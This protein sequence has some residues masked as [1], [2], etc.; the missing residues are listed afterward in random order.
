M[1]TETAALVI[2]RKHWTAYLLP[3]I[4]FGLLFIGG[5]ASLPHSIGEGLKYM[6]I[7]VVLFILASLPI[8]SNH[9]TLREDAVIGKTGFIK[10][11]KLMSPI[12]KV[13]DVSV[14]SGLFGKIFG[15]ST[16]TVSTAGVAG[17]EY[18]FKRVTKADAFQ[19]KIIE[20]ANQ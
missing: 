20:L 3:G 8:R 19:Q 10:T 11:V 4:I 9:L 16:I 12:P 2:C 5:A 6:A 15:Y 7:A 14:R 13:Q 17:V 1:K 18:V